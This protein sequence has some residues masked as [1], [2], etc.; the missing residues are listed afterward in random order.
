MRTPLTRSGPA[1]GVDTSLLEP[2]SE[3]GLGRYI[4]K[5]LKEFLH[6]GMA[7]SEKRGLD[8]RQE[9]VYKSANKELTSSYCG[10]SSVVERQLPKLNVEGS[11]PFARFAG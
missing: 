8:K 7:N 10:R 9:S 3:P 1:R 6:L 4:A 11:R 5:A 2:R